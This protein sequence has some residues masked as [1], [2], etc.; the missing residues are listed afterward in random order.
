M[1][2]HD[3]ILGLMLDRILQAKALGPVYV[4]SFRINVRNSANVGYFLESAALSSRYLYFTSKSPW[5]SIS[6]RLQLFSLKT[7][8]GPS[9]AGIYLNFLKNKPLS[10]YRQL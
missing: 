10:T 9:L 4:S 6:S 2:L 1:H 7:A 5:A 3:I 8:L